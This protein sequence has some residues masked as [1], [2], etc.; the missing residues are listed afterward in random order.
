MCVGMLGSAAAMGR[1]GRWVPRVAGALAAFV[2]ASAVGWPYAAVVA[3][4][5]G[6]EQLA[7]AVGSGVRQG[8]RR[9]AVL[10]GLALGFLAALLLAMYVVDSHYYGRLVVAVWNQIAYN[11]LRRGGGDSTLYG[12]EPWYF[13]LQNGLLNGNVVMLLALAALPLWAMHY[14]VLLSASKKA[15]AAMHALLRG[16]LLLL[17]RVLPF[18]TVLVGF[19]LMAH[20]EERFLSIAYPHMCFNA[21]VA[22]KTLTPLGT[23]AVDMLRRG[24]IGRASAGD[25]RRWVDRLSLGVLCVATLVGFARMAALG[26]YYGAPVRVFSAVSLLGTQQEGQLLP[27][28]PSV[29]SLGRSAPHGTPAVERRQTVCMGDEWH[30]FPSSFWLPQGF[31]VQFV[32]GAFTAQLPGDFTPVAQSGS[33]QRSTSMVRTDFNAVNLWEPLH[34]L[35]STETCD[36]VVAAEYPGHAVH[37]ADPKVWESVECADFL[38]AQRSRVLARVVYVPRR[39]VSLLQALEGDGRP[40]QVWGRLCLFRRRLE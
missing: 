11:V 39:V 40:W 21:A 20:K 19:S 3:V 15:P 36:Y 10:L 18:Y 7:D 6:L 24:G 28:G 29:R 30:H 31:D 22:L 23:W 12:T 34:A 35:N 17:P 27:L 32:R 16:H 9:L 8:A 2:V 1:K 5:F 13:Y 37:L 14:F 38:D 26:T 4:P 33:L 25:V